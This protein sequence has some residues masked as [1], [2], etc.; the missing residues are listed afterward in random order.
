MKEITLKISIPEKFENLVNSFLATAHAAPKVQPTNDEIWTVQDLCSELKIPKSK[1]YSLTMFRG[2][3][4]LPRYKL[5]RTLRFKKDE[6][7]Q[8]FESKR[9]A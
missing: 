6:V 9:V 5:G 7:I 4:C 8:W 3:G 1:I 2:V